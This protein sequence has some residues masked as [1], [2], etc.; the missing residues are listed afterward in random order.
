MQPTSIPSTDNI[1]EE[2]VQ[3]DCE[4]EY[5]QE[6]L[7]DHDHDDHRHNQE[8]QK[9]KQQRHHIVHFDN[10]EPS[11]YPP[12]SRGG[13]LGQ[14]HSPFMSKSSDSHQ[15]PSDVSDQDDYSELGGSS[16]HKNKSKGQNKQ[17]DL[18]SAQH[19]QSSSNQHQHQQQQQQFLHRH[20]QQQEQYQQQ[21]QLQ[22][23]HQHQH[24]QEVDADNCEPI[25]MQPK[26]FK[27]LGFDRERTAFAGKYGLF[28]FRDQY[29]YR[30]QVDPSL[31][32]DRGN[33][34]WTVDKE[35]KIQ[36]LGIPALFIPGNAGSAKQ[37]RAIAKAASKYYYESLPDDQR[38][39]KPLSRPIDFFTGKYFCF[40]YRMRDRSL[41]QMC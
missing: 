31:L 13:L 38:N 27:L 8:Q 10:T 19:Q 4:Q 41:Q 12:Q 37:V 23:Q 2:H 11:S 18:V 3:V 24:Q 26:Y 15:H 21:K 9:K 16:K 6:P 36:P 1:P 5:E 28:L 17:D 20:Q 40:L 34:V 7:Y 33:Y 14:L 25:Y 29:D 35:A 30:L 39:G 32:T 22:Q